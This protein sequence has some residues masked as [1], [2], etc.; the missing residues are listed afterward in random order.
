VRGLGHVGRLLLGEGHR[1]VIERDNE[2]KYR[3]ISWL[4]VPTALFR[5]PLTPATKGFLRNRQAAGKNDGP[6]TS[7]NDKHASVSRERLGV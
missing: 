7:E 2:I 5:P 3:V 6:P 1:A 4:L